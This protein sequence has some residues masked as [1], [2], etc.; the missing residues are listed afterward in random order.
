[1]L[2]KTAERRSGREH[3]KSRKGAPTGCQNVGK[4]TLDALRGE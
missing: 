1:M 2:K 3:G 4:D